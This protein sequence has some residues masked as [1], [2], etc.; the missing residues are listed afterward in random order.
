MLTIINMKKVT[1]SAKENRMLNLIECSENVIM[2]S[3]IPVT[4]TVL[5][6]VLQ[7]LQADI[8]QHKR[9]IIAYYVLFVLSCIILYCTVPKLIVLQLQFVLRAV[10]YCTVLQRLSKC[11][12]SITS[13]SVHRTVLYCTHM[14]RTVRYIV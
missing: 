10:S 6:S 9:E 2:Y 7:N 3:M 11:N 5:N 13:S 12:G 8:I 14:D 1:V 4:G